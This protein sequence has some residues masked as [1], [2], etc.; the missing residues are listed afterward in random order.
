MSVKKKHKKLYRRLVL[1]FLL[2][3][4]LLNVVVGVQTYNF[5]HFKTENVSKTK[6]P[7]KLSSMEKARVLISG[8]QIPKPKNTNIPSTE[9]ITH[10]I[11]GPETLEA[12]E[13]PRENATASVLMFHG[14][15]SSKSQILAYAD[16]FYSLGY[17]PILIDFRAAGGSSGIECS[18]GYHEA[19]DVAAAFRFAQEKFP[20]QPIVLFGVSMGSAAIM[21]AM[22]LYALQPDK[23]IL[24]CP[25]GTMKK[26]VETR[27]DKMGVPK[28]PL[29]DL[30]LLHGSFQMKANI[31]NHNPVEY[32]RHIDRP[33]LLLYG[34]QDKRVSQQETDEIF[35]AL[36]GPKTYYGFPD[37]GHEVYLNKYPAEWKAV[38]ES[39]LQYD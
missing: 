16:V 10:Y 29:V 18:I 13:L 20:Q 39:F 4:V 12:W 37:S 6:R 8:V 21:R 24:E 25:F 35:A 36:A 2:L 5:T 1:S 3:F 11:T 31:Y 15:G 17:R 27:F 33:T 9:F 23:L 38:V 32:A 7:E 28:F 26:T 22:D 19:E 34:Q 30:M 14:Y